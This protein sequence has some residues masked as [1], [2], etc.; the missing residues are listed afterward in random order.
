M[1]TAL[2]E[3]ANNKAQVASQ[4]SGVVTASP[5]YFEED[6]ATLHPV[7]GSTRRRQEANGQFPKR[8]HL[9]TKVIAWRRADVERWLSDPE[10]FAATHKT[11]S[12]TSAPQS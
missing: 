10:G 6:L 1:A 12:T 3:K 8:I 5:W 9:G 4:A 7:S 11:K 2:A